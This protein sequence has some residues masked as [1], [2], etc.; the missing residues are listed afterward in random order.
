MGFVQDQ[1]NLNFNNNDIS[2]VPQRRT[3]IAH[4]GGRQPDPLSIARLQPVG[5][6][7]GAM[8]AQPAHAAGRPCSDYARSIYPDQTFGGSRFHPRLLDFPTDTE[9]GVTASTTS[10]RASA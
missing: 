10:T 8:D 9:G 1:D 6:R 4:H 2:H 5:L 3:A 7:P